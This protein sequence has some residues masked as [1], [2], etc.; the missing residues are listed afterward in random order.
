MSEL[1]QLLH[2][3]GSLS[4]DAHIHANTRTHACIHICIHIYAHSD[5]RTHACTQTRTDA[6]TSMHTHTHT[7]TRTHTC[8]CY[9]HAPHSC[10]YWQQTWRCEPSVWMQPVASWAWLWAWPPRTRRSRATS[11]WN[12]PWVM[13]TGKGVVGGRGQLL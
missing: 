3:I 2:M 10:G 4:P 5:T 1:C 8:E 11:T 6:H 12:W 9:T 7:H 13:W